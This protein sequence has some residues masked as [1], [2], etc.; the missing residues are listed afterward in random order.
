MKGI[1][2]GSR[3]RLAMYLVDRT[4]P[5]LTEDLLAEVQ[6]LLHE[7]A[8]RLSSAGSRFGIS[9]ASTSPKT[10]DA[11]VCSKRPIFELCGR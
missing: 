3:G 4:L 5:G 2:E 1:E 10:I 11:F 9:S 7:A 8:R 6:R